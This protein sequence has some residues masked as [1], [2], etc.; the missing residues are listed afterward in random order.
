MHWIHPRTD[1]RAPTFI[2]HRDAGEKKGGTRPVSFNSESNY[3]A[4]SEFDWSKFR[5]RFVGEGFESAFVK[6]IVDKLLGLEIRFFFE[7]HELKFSAFV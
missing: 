4:R 5:A 3:S 1:G 6:S 2:L 7:Q